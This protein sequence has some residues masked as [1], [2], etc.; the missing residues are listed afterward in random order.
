MAVQLSSEQS[1]DC[2]GNQHYLFS[3]AAKTPIQSIRAQQ[4]LCC[5]QSSL[6]QLSL[7]INSFT[8]Y[9]NHKSLTRNFNFEYILVY[10]KQSYSFS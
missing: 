9:E 1:A 10:G 3:T 4:A 8:G 7:T 2:F 6:L 5:F